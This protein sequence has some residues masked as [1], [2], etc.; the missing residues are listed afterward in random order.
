MHP[1]AE[2]FFLDSAHGQRFCLFH[3]P[4]GR[5]RGALVYVHPFAEEMNKSRRM[6]ALQ[7]RA[8]A[9][10]GIG[11]LLIDLGGCGDSDGEFGHARWAHWKLDLAAASA[12]LLERLERPVGLW[13][14]RL[15]A[16]LALDY[17]REASQPVARLVLWQPVLKG[18]PFLTQFLRLRLAGALLDQSAPQQGGTQALRAALAAGQALEVGGY[19]LSPD[20]AG[21]IDAATADL[22]PPCPVHWFEM[23][24]TSDRPLTPATAALTAAWA[25][26]GRAPTMHQLSCPPFWATQ[27]IAECSAL[28]AA[29]CAALEGQ[30]HAA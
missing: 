16:L 25:S 24:A 29:T 13:G 11:V 7:A 27:E 15:G 12:W 14:L 20:L 9:E 3:A 8:L 26:Q 19:L 28:V 1:A 5:C 23:A 10:A 21:A 22:A 6:A 30:L 17:A 2:P 4:Q 18:S